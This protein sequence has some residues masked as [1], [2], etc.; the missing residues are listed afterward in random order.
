M[1]MK[2][3][4]IMLC[5]LFLIGLLVGCDNK[6]S[7]TST[8]ITTLSSGNI[9]TTPTID[10]ENTTVFQSVTT[11][12]LITS[13]EPIITSTEPII[14]STESISTTESMTSTESTMGVTTS[15]DGSSLKTEELPI[16][17]S[18]YGNTNGNANNQ[19]LVLYDSENKLHYYALGPIVYSYDP[20]TDETAVLFNLS[21]GGHIRNLCLT[22]THLYFVST[23]DSW[24]MRYNLTTKE[25]T[26]VSELETHFI[27]RYDDYVYFDSIDPDYYGQIVRGIKIY[28]HDT[29]SF[30]SGFSSGISSL[31]ISGTKVLYI[32]DYGTRIQLASSTFVGKT[33]EANFDEQG[34]SEIMEMHMIKDSYVDGRTYAFIANTNEESS[35]YLYNSD[36]GLQS[37][38]QSNGLHSLNSDG[39]NLYFINSGAIYRV[40][41][42]TQ[43]TEKIVDVESTS[44]YIYVINYWL[45][46]SN[47][48]L[49]MLYR[50]DPDT[51]E[52]EAL[53]RNE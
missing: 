26:T 17:S 2:K 7:T 47:A 27:S 12:D 50:I 33:T 20:A 29:E 3:I 8:G 22:D 32:Q 11:T 39:S 19:G 5:G 49:S 6:E 30:L 35:I 23:L 53:N 1:N 13:T 24:V 43:N 25:I 15:T 34:F 14:T 38:V 10:N 16:H 42:A 48:E 51:Q 45:Y 40:D 44:K 46:F 18:Y 31:N 21:D 28:R 41:L 9:S 37:V 4:F 36:T 52:V